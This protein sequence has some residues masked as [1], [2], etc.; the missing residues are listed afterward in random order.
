MSSIRVL[1]AEG[2][3]DWRR[4]IRLLL[5]DRPN[6][7]IVCEVADGSAAVA[8]AEE[9]RPDLVV[10]DIG[11]PTLSGTEAAS[12]IRVVSPNSKILLLSQENSPDLVQA[13]V[14][15]G[16]LGCI[17]K[18]YAV[19]ELL[20]AVD[21]L[22]RHEQFFSNT[23]MSYEFP[24]APPIKPRRHEVEFYLGD[25]A[26]VE[27]FV[28][29]ITVALER[30]NS[31]ILIA[32]KSRCDNVIKRL[33]AQRIDVDSAIYSGSFIP[34]DVRE[35]LSAFMIDGMPDES[36]FLEIAGKL[37]EQA[38]K[39]AKPDRTCVALCG[40]CTST[41]WTQDK[42]NAAIRLEQLWDRV[43]RTYDVDILC[44]Y[45]LNTVRKLKGK[46]VLRRIC[47]EHSTFR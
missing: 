19:R 8:K 38:A 45:E 27:G 39:A 20:P 42:P 41:L 29:F 26:F 34:L 17:H 6:L 3:E 4:Q 9:L 1:V 11:L 16:A 47:E 14:R 44:G 15:S 37:I 33:K 18:L 24:E 12:E 23:L 35:T 22:L 28:R 7:R 46:Q 10:L 21:A 5:Q 30:G 2:C 32:S 25:A 31:V 36:R 40:E 43:S 13:A